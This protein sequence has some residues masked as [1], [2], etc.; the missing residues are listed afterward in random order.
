MLHLI[1]LNPILWLYTTGSFNNIIPSYSIDVLVNVQAIIME[2][3][4]LSKDLSFEKE[5]NDPPLSELFDNAFELFNSINNTQEPIN[6]SKV[7]YDIKRAMRMF[8]D[9]TRLVSVVDMFS[10]NETFEEIA[11]ENLKYFLLP[12]L[13]GKLTMK[14]CNIDDRMHLIK[15]AEIYFIDFLKRLKVYGLTNVEIPEINLTEEKEIKD[16]KKS[17][18]LEDMVI[19]RNIKLQRYKQEKDLESHLDTLK[20]NLDNP[21]ID[22]EIK[23]EYFIT[24]LR[25]YAVQIIDELNFLNTEKTIL[26]N[27]KE[28]GSMCTSTSESQKTLKQK[29]SIS[30]LQPIIITRDEVQKKV[31]G[32]GYPSLP[33]LTVQ[34][35]YEQRVK[36]GDWPDPL[37][38]N[39][40]NSRC[41]QD[42][43]NKG[44]NDEDNEIILKE[45]MEEKDD[46]EYLEQAR[47]MD[48]YKDVH[49]RGWG[50]RANRS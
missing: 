7:Q 36:D 22:D 26:E 38:H 13:L 4:V 42:M 17:T 6:S 44:T 24:L 29:S 19:R 31:F 35:F 37:Q 46:P 2:K 14:I 27:M 18:M 1:F 25:L 50:N 30:K 23:R 11:T 40:T 48:E 3:G 43:T 9:A 49:R 45:E 20:K 33:V 28:I 47:S 5:K 21:N 8:E 10:N 39:T 16:V 34:E 32:A 41:L 12:A 15:V